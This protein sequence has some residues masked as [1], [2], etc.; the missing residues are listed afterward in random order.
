MSIVT[1]A[2]VTCLCSRNQQDVDLACGLPYKVMI[3]MCNM[4]RYTTGQLFSTCIPIKQAAK[5][6][7]SLTAYD[8]SEKLRWYFCASC[9]SH[10]FISRNPNQEWK[11]CS[12]A[13]DNILL[14]LEN[15]RT[16]L[17][18]IQ[19]HEFVADTKD[20]G[21][22]ICLNKSRGRVIPV[23]LNGADQP[24]ISSWLD[25]RRELGTSPEGYLFTG[26]YYSTNP[27]ERPPN[28]SVSLRWHTVLH[29]PPGRPIF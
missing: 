6:S 20:G 16:A 24:P 11:I 17:T 26:G 22:S 25:Y 28:G 3:C 21:L 23:H 13:V 8:S 29:H 14:Q 18:D 10:M 27:D 9:G 1:A 2:R 19:R 5:S 15:Q 4:C 7:L 12:G